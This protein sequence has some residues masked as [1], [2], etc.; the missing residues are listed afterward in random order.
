MS[1]KRKLQ[2]VEFEK[3]K[4]KMRKLERSMKLDSSSS[5]S[6]TEGRQTPRLAFHHPRPTSMKPRKR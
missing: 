3:L 4:K 1:R 2:K 5:E 6:D